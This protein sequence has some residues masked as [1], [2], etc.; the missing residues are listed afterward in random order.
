M[1]KADIERVSTTGA[2]VLS[3]VGVC[4]MYIAD[5]GRMSTT[6]AWGLSAAGRWDVRKFR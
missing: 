3:T 1:S 5:I 2:L 6:S 4:R